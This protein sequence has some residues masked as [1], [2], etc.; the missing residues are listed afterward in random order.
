VSSRWMQNLLAPP[1]PPNG[2][3]DPEAVAFF[4]EVYDSVRGGPPL[5]VMLDD[6]GFCVPV[7]VIGGGAGAFLSSVSG[8]PLRDPLHGVVLWTMDLGPIG[9]RPFRV[10]ISALGPHPLEGAQGTG[11]LAVSL[12]RGDAVI[13]V[14]GEIA[15]NPSVL[16]RLPRARG[17]LVAVGSRELRASI[18]AEAELVRTGDRTPL[19]VLQRVV[20][21][22]VRSAG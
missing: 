2:P 12:A 22:S 5:E 1:P 3:V 16:E 17:A 21:K 20:K 4:D 6:G 8:E 10:P 9:D 7:L 11:Q 15:L 18:D 13:V 19:Q 14:E